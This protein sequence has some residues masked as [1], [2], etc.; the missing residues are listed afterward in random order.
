MVE[1]LRRASRGKVPAGLGS[2]PF[3]LL[4]CGDTYNTRRIQNLSQYQR[5][6]NT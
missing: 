6:H 4:V 2:V 5:Q 3:L 1:E